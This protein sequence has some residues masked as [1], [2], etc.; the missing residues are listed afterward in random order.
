MN[1]DL[2]GASCL[3]RNRDA[4]CGHASNLDQAKMSDGALAA[5]DHGH[6]LPVLRVTPDRLVDRSRRLGRHP[7][8]DRLIGAVNAVHRELRRQADMALVILGDHHQAADILIQPMH[9]PWPE[10]AA[11]PGQRAFAMVEKGVDQRAGR[12][13]GGGMHD[14]AGR[15]LQ[16]QKMLVFVQNLQRDRLRLGLRRLRVGNRDG[17]M[18][19]RFDPCR[20]VGYLNAVPADL[21]RRNQGLEPCSG[22]RRQPGGQE[23]VEALAGV[24]GFGLDGDVFWHDRSTV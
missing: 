8:D 3:E 6:A 4:R 1:T 2:M 15:L 14:H 19:T 16:H 13:A 7:P 23:L 20:A 12:M 17:K 10:N 11:N 24:V 18:L 22:Q 9:D 5:A 21:A